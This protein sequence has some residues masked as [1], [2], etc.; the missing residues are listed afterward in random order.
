MI[1]FAVST[2]G[3]RPSVALCKD[4]AILAYL[5]GE[6]GHT[7]SETLMPLADKLLAEAGLDMSKIDAYAADI[8]PGSFTGVRIGVCAVNAMASIYHKSVVGV[9]ALE[10]L[11]YGHEGKVCALIDARN[12]NAYAAVYENGTCRRAPEAIELAPY[13]AAI[14]SGMLFAG[15]GAE[16]YREQI[17]SNFPDAHF[18][19]GELRADHVALLAYAKLLA[20]SVEEEIY[21]MYLRPSQA[22]RLFEERHK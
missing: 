20:G 15:D 1:L 14:D 2:S 18:A 12:G 21:P 6:S 5:Q 11:C 16:A 17:C 22:E 10:A 8:G 3:P 9:S 19:F 13:L 7:H 4:G